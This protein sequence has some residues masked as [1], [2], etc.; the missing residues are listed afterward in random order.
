MKQTKKNHL[1]IKIILQLLSRN[2]Y[3][4]NCL[5]KKGGKLQ[6]KREQKFILN[7]NSK[8]MIEIMI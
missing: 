3:K 1:F 8:L 5:I 6:K 7:S 2:L 4:S